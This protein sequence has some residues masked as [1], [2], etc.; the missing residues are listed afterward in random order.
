MN[1][2]YIVLED[3][4][5]KVVE[6]PAPIQPEP[7]VV[8]FPHQTAIQQ[9]ID[10]KKQRRAEVKIEQDALVEAAENKRAD[11]LADFDGQI[12][13]LEDIKTRAELANVPVDEAAEEE[14]VE[15]E[16]TP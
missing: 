4:S 2:E 15:E 10:R 6:T 12:A 11:Y 3:G 5:F 14:P 16:V 8:I 7:K 1:T 13:K 9:E